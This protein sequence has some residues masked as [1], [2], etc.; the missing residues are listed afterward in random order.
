MRYAHFPVFI[1]LA[2]MQ[3]F[4]QFHEDATFPLIQID[5]HSNSVYMSMTLETQEEKD[6]P[7]YI[8]NLYAYVSSATV[9][10]DDKWRT[11]AIV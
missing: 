4:I 9:P 2:D 3:W 11:P 7:V 10:G 1:Y 8:S 5:V 6:R